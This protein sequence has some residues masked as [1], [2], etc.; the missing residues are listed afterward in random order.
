MQTGAAVGTVCQGCLDDATLRDDQ[1]VYLSFD[2]LKV[3]IQL[4]LFQRRSS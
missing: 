2:P 1:S 4:R 3:A